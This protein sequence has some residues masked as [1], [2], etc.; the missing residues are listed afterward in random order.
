MLLKHDDRDGGGNRSSGPNDGRRRSF[1]IL[2]SWLGIAIGLW[3]LSIASLAL[4]TPFH[5]S[6]VGKLLLVVA[7]LTAL[8]GTSILVVQAV[9]TWRSASEHVESRRGF[10]YKQR[11]GDPQFVDEVVYW[12]RRTIG[13]AHPDADLI[14][15][16]LEENPEVLRVCLREWKNGRLKFCGYVLLY[17]I[18]ERIAKGILA[19]S[20][21]SESEFGPN[22]LSPNFEGARYLYIGMILGTDR[23]A[24][25][26]VTD[27]LRAELAVILANE[28]IE[29]VFARPGSEGGLVLMK[30]Y[31][32]K[33]I[34]SEDGVWSV[35]AAALREQ[36]RLEQIPA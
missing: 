32:F 7:L 19:G 20:I 9:E 15:T 25:P 8:G 31:G 23:H 30:K 1:A 27:R 26:H 34:A 12:G 5:H 6:L 11:I 17:P 29:T 22:P 21:R 35:S 33:P 24:R 10:E 14:D 2:L 18:K 16:R 3:S 36:L 28:R 4:Y 13:D